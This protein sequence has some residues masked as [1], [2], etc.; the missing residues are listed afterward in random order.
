MTKRRRVTSTVLM[1]GLHAVACAPTVPPE[2]ARRAD[3][4]DR[5]YVSGHYAEAAELWRDAA[6]HATSAS[7]A[8]E[9]R[10]RRAVSLR[11]AGRDA[12]ANAALEEIAQSKSPRAPRALTDLA[13]EAERNGDTATA[14]AR[15]EELIAQYPGSGGADHAVVRR[16]ANLSESGGEPAVQSYLS[17]LQGKIR[18]TALRER[19][20]YELARSLERGGRLRS[21]ARAYRK[22]AAEHPYPEGALWDDAVFRG[23]MIDARLGA[24]KRAIAELEAMLSHRE[25]AALVGSYE[26]PRF[27]EARFKIAELYRDALGDDAG[28]RDAFLKLWSDHPTSLLRD[29]ALWQ[30][31]LLAVRM[32]KRDEACSDARTLTREMPESRFAPCADIVCPSIRTTGGRCHDY[33][34]REAAEELGR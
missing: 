33:V 4:A 19:I 5:A 7:D 34:R 25:G 3:A 15:W 11:R 20:G 8:H 16:I 28:A 18:E 31:A 9:A 32:G 14:T 17:G 1:L 21:A 2:Y 12:E 22:V 29:D 10:Y 6:Q 27:A 23:A 26:R 24:P 30:A 13:A